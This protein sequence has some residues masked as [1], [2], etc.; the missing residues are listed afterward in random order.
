[1]PGRLDVLGRCV[2]Q[3]FVEPHITTLSGPHS[4]GS[5]P[6]IQSRPQVV[7]VHL[8]DITDVLEREQ[9]RAVVRREP[10]LGFEE[11]RL[12]AWIASNRVLSV[13]IDG[14]FEDGK[15]QPSLTFH[16]TATPK[17]RKVLI[18]KKNVRLE[19]PG[20]AAAF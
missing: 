20:S 12:L 5:T 18:R 8:Q 11:A 15:H 14:V 16:C 2:L 17:S 19:Q 13:A 3:R 9:P 1:M 10:F 4:N 7:G 6:P